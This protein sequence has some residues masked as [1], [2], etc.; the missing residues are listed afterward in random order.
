MFKRQRI[1]IT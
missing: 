1:M